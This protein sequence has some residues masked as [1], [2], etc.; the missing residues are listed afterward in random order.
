MIKK[1]SNLIRNMKYGY[2]A[3]SVFSYPE[4]RDLTLKVEHLGFESAHVNDHFIDNYL[5]AMMLT[6]A[7][8]VETS[9]IKLFFSFF[10]FS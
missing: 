8:A 5:E 10:S 9:K 4:I 2:H 1:E 6:S 7:L 3:R